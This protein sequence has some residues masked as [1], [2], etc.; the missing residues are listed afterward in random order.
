[1]PITVLNDVIL[2]DC[3]ARQGVSG[4]NV[5]VNFRSYNRG[6]YGQATISRSRTLRQI[7]LAIVPLPRDD[8]ETLETLHE[9][10]EGGAYGMLAHDPKDYVCTTGRLRAY[11][12]GLD[13][14]GV[15]EGY[16]VPVYRMYQR[17]AAMG[18]ARTFDRRV[19]RPQSPSVLTRNASPVTLGVGAGQAA[20]NYD[21]GTV[22]FVA[23]ATRNVTA[24]TVGA[25]TQITLATALPTMVVGGRLYLTGLTGA[26]AALLNSLSHSITA[27]T[28]GGL[29]VY[30]LSTN[31]AGKTITTGSGV[32]YKYPQPADALAWTGMFY[33]PVQFKEDHIDWE[34]VRGGAYENR[35]IAGPS[36]VLIEVMEP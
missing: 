3:I 7:D 15:G 18:T 32:G 30:T 31:T 16:G 5:R 14:G 27:I 28:G 29:N 33:I 11:H 20:I 35:L 9:V 12:G 25:T 36:V 8:W 13:V 6:G 2:P 10:T 21:T 34:G 24:V 26:D 1:M 23:D 17:K 22:T 4:R 19:T